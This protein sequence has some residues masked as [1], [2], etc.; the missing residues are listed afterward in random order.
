MHSEGLRVDP[1]LPVSSSSRP[2]KTSGYLREGGS[3]EGSAAD[4][5]PAPREAPGQQDG[6]GPAHAFACR[7]TTWQELRYSI[8]LAAHL[9]K[10]MRPLSWAEAMSLTAW[11]TH[12]LHW[13]LHRQSGLQMGSLFFWTRSLTVWWNLLLHWFPS[14]PDHSLLFNTFI[15]MPES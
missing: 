15:C 10:A 5:P 3:C 7:T 8:S 12:W 4:A 9:L 14:M 11:L 6:L 1:G 13:S 2:L